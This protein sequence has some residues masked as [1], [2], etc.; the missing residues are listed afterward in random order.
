MIITL[1]D[2]IFLY[3]KGHEVNVL[4]ILCLKHNGHYELVMNGAVYNRSNDKRYVIDNIRGRATHIELGQSDEVIDFINEEIKDTFDYADINL[5]PDEYLLMEDVYQLPDSGDWKTHNEVAVADVEQQDVCEH[6]WAN[7]WEGALIDN[8]MINSLR[9]RSSYVIRGEN[10]V[11]SRNIKF[12]VRHRP[13]NILIVVD[14]KEA[15]E[16][17]EKLI[18]KTP[19]Y[20]I[21]FYVIKEAGV[22]LK[23]LDKGDVEHIGIIKHV[24]S[25]EQRPDI[26]LF[27]PYRETQFIKT[28]S[29]II[30]NSSKIHSKFSFKGIKCAQIDLGLSV[31]NLHHEMLKFV[32]ESIADITNVQGTEAS[33]SEKTGVNTAFRFN[34]KELVQFY[35]QIC[36]FFNLDD[37]KVKLKLNQYMLKASQAV[38]KLVESKWLANSYSPEELDGMDSQALSKAAADYVNKYAEHVTT[39]RM[40]LFYDILSTDTA[41]LYASAIS[42]SFKDNAD[43]ILPKAKEKAR[44]IVINKLK[45]KYIQDNDNELAEEELVS[46][47]QRD[48]NKLLNLEVVKIC[49]SVLNSKKS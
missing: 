3:G 18:T 1:D 20:K 46:L 38:L 45:D 19:L 33:S 48:Y 5:P 21:K 28:E 42:K 36:R 37:Q 30:Q 16:T 15:K 17:A 23:K 26:I 34:T 25:Q 6:M 27:E 39:V 8:R 24:I 4:K 35:S 44:L 32:D 12:R 43:E 47:Y 14:H 10:Y 29:T 11:R 40:S 49:S 9:R 41:K 22:N 2:F 13:R 7:I 31:E